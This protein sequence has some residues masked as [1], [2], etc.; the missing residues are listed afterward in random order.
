MVTVVFLMETMTQPTLSPLEGKMENNPCQCK[1][2]ASQRILGT[3]QREDWP[4][5]VL[6]VPPPPFEHAMILL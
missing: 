2:K 4:S 5:Q 1:P 6:Q 3:P